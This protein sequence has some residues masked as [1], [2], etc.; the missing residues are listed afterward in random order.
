[1]FNW[2]SRE[3]IASIIAIY[4]FIEG[5]G[6]SLNFISIG[7]ISDD[8]SELNLTIILSIVGILLLL[9]MIPVWFYLEISPL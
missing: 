8:L 3:N 4:H 7:I 9:V 5:I 2:F 1:M 6:Q